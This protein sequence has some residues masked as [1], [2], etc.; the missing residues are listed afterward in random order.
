MA[1]EILQKAQTAIVLADSV[2]PYDGDLGARTDQLNLKDVAA[3]A[4]RQ[5]AKV[6][7]GKAS[8]LLGTRFAVYAALE[9]ASAPTSRDN[10]DFYVGFS[11]I[12]T[13]GTANPGGLSGADAAYSGTVGD[14]LDDSLPQL[15][16]IGTM[17]AT[18]D[19]DPVVQF[20]FIGW[21]AAAE[22][23]AS[24]V[25]DNNSAVAFHS[26]AV[27]MAIRVVPYLDEVQ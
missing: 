5:S 20:Q 6:D 19:G 23:Y 17:I 13:P 8:A 25:V 1:N 16:Y 21:F 14:V 9:F 10:V 4:A 15:E 12:V 22:R 3:G 26:D 18:A 24:F 7:L 2:E 27:E 11:P